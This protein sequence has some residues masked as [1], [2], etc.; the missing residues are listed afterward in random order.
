MQRRPET[1]DLCDLLNKGTHYDRMHAALMEDQPRR[2]PHPDKALHKR[3]ESYRQN[4]RR[5]G[6][7]WQL[8]REDFKR[9]IQGALP[10]LR[11]GSSRRNRP[12]HE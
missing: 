4:A 5:K 12:N 7:H 9:L 2:V 10:L 1:A 11:A 3:E 8:D 6:I